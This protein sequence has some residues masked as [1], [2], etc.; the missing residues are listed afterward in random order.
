MVGHEALAVRVPALV[1]SVATGL[2]IYPLAA[3]TLR[4]SRLALA[5][6]AVTCTIPIFAVGA[7]LMTIDAPL[8][9][10]F[11]WTLVAVERGLRTGHRGPWLIAGLMIALGILAKYTMVLIFPIVGLTLL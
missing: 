2:G 9:C 6:V 11:V 8:A 7:I 5:A 1:L 4:S 3:A 10:L